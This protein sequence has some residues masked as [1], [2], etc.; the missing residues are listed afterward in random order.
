MVNWKEKLTPEQ[1][2]ILREAGTEAPFSGEYND[3]FS[4]GVYC[5]AGCETELF[6]SGEKF[7]SSC[8]WPSFF[9]EMGNIEQQKDMSHGMKRIEVVCKN[10]KGHLGHVFTDGPE[11]TGLRYCINSEAL[12]FKELEANT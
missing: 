8:G 5:C 7:R 9:D 4:E 3:H 2:R 6:M 10:C 12:E 11:P 1:Y